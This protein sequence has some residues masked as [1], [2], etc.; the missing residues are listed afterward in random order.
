VLCDGKNVKFGSQGAFEAKLIVD[1]YSKELLE[2]S[3]DQYLEF[4][5]NKLLE[6]SI[7]QKVAKELLKQNYGTSLTLD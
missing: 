7:N 5:I 6:N 1:Q 4:Q 3:Q 2:E